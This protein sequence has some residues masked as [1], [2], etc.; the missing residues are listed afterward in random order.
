MPHL[1]PYISLFSLLYKPGLGVTGIDPGMTFTSFPSSI[2]QDSNPQPFDRESSSLPTRPDSRPWLTWTLKLDYFISIKRC[3]QLLKE[4]SFW[5][6]VVIQSVYQVDG[7]EEVTLRVLDLE[8]GARR[9]VRS[10]L[11]SYFKNQFLW[12]KFL[13]ARPAVF[14][15]N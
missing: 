10:I 2:G 11:R 13:K 4:A 12:C 6:P 3:Y 5:G 8:I 9:W 14:L 1:A 7:E 15:I